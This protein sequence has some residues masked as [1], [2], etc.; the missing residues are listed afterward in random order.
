M[1]ENAFRVQ[2][3]QVRELLVDEYIAAR[4]V[5]DEYGGGTV[6]YECLKPRFALPDALVQRLAL[7][8]LLLQKRVGSG[9]FNCAFGDPCL[10]FCVQPVQLTVLSA[11]AET[12]TAIESDS[13]AIGTS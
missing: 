4:Q 8:N 10:K 1:K 5:L 2:P 6:V 9:Q 12:S 7:G 13:N 3:E 11:N